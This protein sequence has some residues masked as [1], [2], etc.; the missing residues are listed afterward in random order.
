MLSG[1]KKL[2]KENS[3][4]NLTIAVASDHGGF[5]L[6]EIL[7]KLLAERGYQPVDLGVYKEEPCDYP[8]YGIKLIKGILL[9]KFNRGILACRSGIGFSILANRFSGIRAALCYNKRAASF[10][11][12]HNNSNVLIL[13]GDFI[14]RKDIKGI[15]EAWL[16]SEFEGGRHLRRLR[17]IEKYSK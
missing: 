17:Q 4:K 15:L 8:K 3:A 16:N 13:A 5:G 9:K 2:N 10:S 12:R 6:K 7:K 1:N 11:R 14:K